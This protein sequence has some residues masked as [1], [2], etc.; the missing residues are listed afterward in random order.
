MKIIKHGTNYSD[1]TRIGTC[2][3]CKCEFELDHQDKT[4]SRWLNNDTYVETHPC[5]DCE[6]QNVP[7]ETSYPT[8]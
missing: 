8:I 2:P 6:Y 3:Y 5:P 1:K 4:S 7:I